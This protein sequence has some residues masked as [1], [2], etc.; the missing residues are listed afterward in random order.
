MK[1]K[2]RNATGLVVLALLM[3]TMAGCQVFPYL[4]AQF[5]PPKKVKALYKPEAKRKCLVFVDDYYEVLD[6]EPLKAE[7]TEQINEQLLKQKIAS[8]TVSY[9]QLLEV[10]DASPHFN[11]LSVSE[12]G[13]KLGVET[14]VYVLIDKFSL[15]DPDASLLWRGNLQVTVRL[16]GTKAGRLWPQDRPEGY[17]VP[18]VKTPLVDDASPT[19]AER[20]SK[21]LAARMG[22]R[23]AKL[24]YDHRVSAEQERQD[25]AADFGD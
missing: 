16:V 14:V 19:Y 22:D 24:F 1:A 18:A 9:Q 12:V 8:E 21:T 4:V 5:A 23:I 11:R 3:A 6:Y 20:I 10:T 2:C 25:R 13:Q 15:K 7:L 17:P